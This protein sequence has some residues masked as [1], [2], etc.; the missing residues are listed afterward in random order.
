MSELQTSVEGKASA[1]RQTSLLKAAGFIAVL[2]LASKGLGFIRD[3]QIFHV[4]GAGLATDAYFAAVQLPWYA[5]IL[6]GGLGGPVHSATVSI[7]SKLLGDDGAT[8]P[9]EA[10]RRLA[11]Q[12]LLLLAAVF[13]GLS[14]GVWFYSTEIMTLFIGTER[15]ELLALASGQLRVMAPVLFFGGW[16]GLF[17][18]LLNV[19]NHYFWPSMA[20]A[21]MNVV[22]IIA[23]LLSPVD[24]NGW[25]LAWATLVGAGLQLFV[26]L[27]P[28]WA[29]GF[30]P[31]IAK[32]GWLP[33]QKIELKRLGELLF[34]M[35][36]GTT[37]GQL[38]VFVDLFF[39]NHLSEGGWSAIVLSNRLLQLPIGVLQ[40]AM[41]VPLFPRFGR[42]VEA[43]DWPTLRRDLANGI[44][45]LW[46]LGAP[47]LV[48]LW[49]LGEPLI[50]VVFEYG[51]FDAGD[52]AMVTLALSFQALQILPYF[53]RDT[54]TRVFYAMEDSMTPLMV[55]VVA[56]AVKFAANWVFVQWFGL[57]GI[58]LSTSVITFVNMLL[59]G[60]LLARK[61]S[62]NGEPLHF[63]LHYLSR[64]FIKILVSGGVYAAMVVGCWVLWQQWFNPAE[65][66]M[67][68]A[69]CVVA[70]VV[71]LGVYIPCCMLLGVDEL[72]PLTNRLKGILAR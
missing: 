35:L 70:S 40:T 53:A 32:K 1:S 9:N 65:T 67:T 3:W 31:S 8:Q 6:V 66:V 59:L 24:P 56:I 45:S 20:P 21:V 22:M 23:L 69:G 10:T 34:P 19:V 72:K 60:G 43:A 62:Q 4:Y 36:V 52:T 37:I 68:I 26:Q 29:K 18:G 44:I 58:T 12:C 46:I 25:V 17:Y 49:I 33:I 61:K 55:S 63:G 11:N 71:P 39:V 16:I 27:P 5:L 54:F 28:L 2:T 38:L 41:L 51:A 47:M 15:P 42:A 7:F 30:I 50:R 14:L 13:G 48:V 57:G 64:S